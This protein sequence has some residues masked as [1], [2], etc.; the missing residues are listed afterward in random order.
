MLNILFYGNC[1]SQ[2]LIYCLERAFKANYEHF[3]N[4]E[5]IHEKKELPIDLIKK[6]D[7]FIYQPTKAKH[8]IYSTDPNI[9][10]GICSYLSPNCKKI[11]FPYIYN[12]AM[13]V[14]VP[15]NDTYK[16]MEPII[17]LKREGHSVENIIDKFLKGEI[18]F[19]HEKRFNNCM[20]IL[21]EKESECDVKV[22][23]FILRNIFFTRLFLTQNHPTIHLYNHCANQILPL[24][25]SNKEIK[26]NPDYDENMSNLPGNFAHTTYDVRF[27]NFKYPVVCWDKRWSVEIKRMYD[28]I[29]D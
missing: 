26:H 25:G 1:Q 8:G 21:R 15:E 28:L 22:V 17:K 20:S 6:A 18:D 19:E 5:Y 29:K 12:S 16:G 2:G 7:V 24:L 13:W 14:F 9:E 11:S 23:D 10:N 27:W 4:Y 3:V